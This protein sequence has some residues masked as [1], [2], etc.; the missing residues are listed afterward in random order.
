MS[1]K[2]KKQPAHVNHE[3]WLVSYADFITLMFA[4]FVVMF[5]SSQVDKKKIGNLALAV[6][7]AFQELGVFNASNTKM[8]LA[9]SQPMPF[10]KIQMV[11][12][13]KD[14]TNLGRLV[15]VA[16]GH[17]E[18]SPGIDDLK[19]LQQQLEQALAPEIQRRAVTLN[20]RSEHLMLS[21]KEIGFFDSGA[22]Q[23]RP[24]LDGALARIAAIL[25]KHPHYLRIEGH[26]DNVPIHN[27]QF[28][29]NWELSTARATEITRRFITRYGLSPEHLAA[30]GYAEFH[31]L[32][33]NDTAAG[34]AANRRVDIIILEPAETWKPSLPAGD[35]APASAEL[36]KEVLQQFAEPKPK[37]TTTTK[38]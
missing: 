26:T 29:S 6:Q 18:P 14:T 4:F 25:A 23:V 22:A 21:L 32:S 13:L 8:P 15:S 1:R 34:R 33:S 31:P 3:R 28:E 20:A 24:E 12:N 37:K 11:E 19:S 38:G 16:E 7:V 35:V 5:S 9:T 27:A 2:R 36:K 10:S 30:A 17:L